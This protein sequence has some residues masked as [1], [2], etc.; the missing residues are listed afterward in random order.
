MP[1]CRR[2]GGGERDDHCWNDWHA[3]ATFIST[4]FQH[5]L[6]HGNIGE[7]SQSNGERSEGDRLVEEPAYR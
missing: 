4:F 5:V 3:H 7:R 6:G 2:V 1:L